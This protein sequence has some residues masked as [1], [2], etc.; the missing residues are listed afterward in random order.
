ML[1]KAT[2][3]LPRMG[4]GGDA[5]KMFHAFVTSTSHF[6][7]QKPSNI[8]RLNFFNRLPFSAQQTIHIKL[9]YPEI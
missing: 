4:G 6:P 9:M 5:G 1:N 7:V 3:I 8:L 2:S